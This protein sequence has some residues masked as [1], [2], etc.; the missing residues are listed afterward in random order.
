MI[1][2]ARRR[3]Q[4]A[5][6]DSTKVP[7]PLRIDR[8]GVWYGDP[9]KTAIDSLS[10]HDAL[11][12]ARCLDDP[13]G[14][15]FTAQRRDRLAWA[16]IRANHSTLRRLRNLTYAERHPLDHGTVILWLSLSEPADVPVLRLSARHWLREELGVKAL[17]AFDRPVPVSGLWASREHRLRIV[18]LANE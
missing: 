7:D 9:L 2:H 3:R 12:A 14:V 13:N 15:A 11:R 16:S 4:V 18:S 8:Y 10:L 17:H 5:R 6:F 1:S